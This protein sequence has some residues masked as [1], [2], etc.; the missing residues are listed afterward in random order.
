[1]SS[2]KLVLR[3]L[4]GGALLGAF[5]RLLLNIFLQ[6]HWGWEEIFLGAATGALLGLFS[7]MARARRE[8]LYSESLA[9][10]AR[11]AGF[12]HTPQP[13]PEKLAQLKSFPLLGL[14]TF[15]SARH[16]LARHDERLAVEMFDLDLGDDDVHLSVM[17][18]VLFPRAAE[19]LPDFW[20]H[21][22]RPD[23]GLP[24]GPGITFEAPTE[25]PDAAAVA[26]FGQEYRLDP[27]VRILFRVEK[28][29]T[30]EPTS[31]ERIC[32]VFSLD[33]LRFFADNPG[34]H[35]QAHAG[36]LALWRGDGVVAAAD[37]PDLLVDALHV[38]E[39]LTGEPTPGQ[40][41]AAN[42]HLAPRRPSTAVEVVK[43]VVLGLFLGWLLWLFLTCAVMAALA[44]GRA[45]AWLALATLV[46]LPLGAA[47]AGGWLSYRRCQAARA[48]DPRNTQAS[49]VSAP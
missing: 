22:R 39:K 33:A 21:P 42:Y 19:G 28:G 10:L 36:H 35:A 30:L 9:E 31:L 29:A 14:G 26:R 27:D 47:T 48:R 25:H 40:A 8:R 49:R 1:M 34:W 43:G 44:P 2:R 45:G 41:L 4:I 23:P 5:C 17:T 7:G 6:F 3:G 15:L 20:L 37:R 32:R 12:I 24:G 38:L 11:E 46:I 13:G 16:H 18:L